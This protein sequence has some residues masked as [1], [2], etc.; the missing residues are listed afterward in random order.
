LASSPRIPDEL[1]HFLR[2]GRTLL[3]KGD[4]GTGK[5]TLAL[6]ILQSL[7]PIDCVYFSTRTPPSILYEYYPWLRDK[8]VLGPEEI[9]FL[10]THREGPEGLLNTLRDQLLKMESP[11]LIVDTWDA[12]AAEM[13]PKEQL[14]TAKAIIMTTY[15]TNGRTI[16]TE[17]TKETSFLDFLVDGVVSLSCSDVYGE[18]EGGR[19]YEDRL[20]RRSAREMDLKKLKGTRISNKRY[21]FTLE[22]GRF[23]HLPPF[24]EDLSVRPV[25]ITDLADKRISSGVPDLDTI[26]KGFRKGSFNL[27]EVE[28]GV[29]LRYLQIQLQTALNAVMNRKGVI[30]VPSIGEAY[31]DESLRSMIIHRPSANDIRGEVESMKKTA[32]K[33]FDSEQLRNGLVILLGIDTFLSRFG[34]SDTTLTVLDAIVSYARESGATIV[35]T[36]KRA[37][38]FLEYATH[39]ADSHIVFKDLNNALVIYGMRPKTGLYA[40]DLIDNQV[41]L[42]P[43]V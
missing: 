35:G 4:A 20:E 30:I 12:M 16:L 39:I 1:T 13:D 33:N 40:V 26:T 2:T 10:E 21:T 32:E 31:P 29:D 43:V 23:R 11:F 27:F 34:S 8:T 14:R 41:R 38:E 36:M 3:I 18:S 6:E 28:H 25:K 24:R 22:G 17:E 37:I 5:T 42:I 9:R 19:V 7:E 15:G